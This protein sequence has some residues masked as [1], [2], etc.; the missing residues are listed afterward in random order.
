MHIQSEYTSRSLRTFLIINLFVLIIWIIYLLKLLIARISRYL[1]ISRNRLPI[2]K[3]YED[4]YRVKVDILKYIFL[5]CCFTFELFSEFFGFMTGHLASHDDRKPHEPLRLSSSCELLPV[6]W[7]YRLYR[8]RIVFLMCQ[9]LW[10][11]CTILALSLFM[12]MLHIQIR[13]YKKSLNQM[14][15]L[16]P[17]IVLTL[18]VVTLFVL[19]I[20]KETAIFGSVLYCM[21][22]LL[23]YIITVYKVI[24]FGKILKEIRNDSSD[25]VKNSYRKGYYLNKLYFDDQ[26]FKKY[27]IL[28]V[29]ILFFLGLDLFS[30]FV[31]NY[32]NVLISSILINPCWFNYVYKINLDFKLSNT[33]IQYIMESSD[34][35]TIVRNIT[36]SC[37]ILGFI[38]LSIGIVFIPKL[39]SIFRKCC[40]KQI[41]E[42]SSQLE[43]KLIHN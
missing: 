24:R 17:G 15:Y 21:L 10:Y 33:T 14:R 40:K 32:F 16:F 20:V 39:Y 41:T 2:N 42:S 27:G 1:K 8:F 26:N 7:L 35:L 3:D 34:Y 31:Y 43:E 5:I 23:I 22:F 29:S 19:S 18:T 12:W 4:Q 9:A 37:Y 6:G 30:Q 36:S 38:C 28:V 13:A 11:C 25:N